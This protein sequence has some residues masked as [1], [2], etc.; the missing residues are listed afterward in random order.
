MKVV[1]RLTNGYSLTPNLKDK[2]LINVSPG[3][4]QIGKH[5]LNKLKDHIGN[6]YKSGVTPLEISH[7]SPEFKKIKDSLDKNIRTFM[8]IPDDFSLI[9]TQGGGHGQFSAVPLNFKRLFPNKPAFYIV[10]GTWSDRASKEAEKV[11]PIDTIFSE[12]NLNPLLYKSIPNV[13][14]DLSSYS[15]VYLCSNETVN[16]TEYSESRFPIPSRD[17]LGE[18]TKLVV[19]MSSDFGTKR[20][21]W[22]KIDVAF[23]CSSKNLGTAGSTL[24]IIRNE[25][26]ES[27][28]GNTDLYIPSILDWKLY[29]DSD[30][31]YNTP[32]VFN[33]YLTDLIFKDYIEKYTDVNKLER[34]NYEKANLIY[35]S[36]R[37][38]DKL[39]LC[40]S[41]EKI[42]SFMNIPFTVVENSFNSFIDYCFENNIVGLRTKTPFN[43]KELNTDE[44]LRISLYNG[45]SLEETKKIANLIDNFR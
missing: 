36:I 9:W 1:K 44:P 24:L 33:I 34:I 8:N 6:K 2:D 38:N 31:L 29:S 28:N 11:L 43:W 30:S 35:D 12:R 7:R 17:L 3:P 39:K 26:I 20:I 18:N 15:Y 13:L 27:F 23:A 21:D 42:Q 45:V 10:S 4:T 41:D 16:G 19:D 40:I 25:L 14:P 32:A 37:N 22:D 5:L